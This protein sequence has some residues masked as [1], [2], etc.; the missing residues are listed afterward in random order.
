M[1]EADDVIAL[2]TE[3]NPDGSIEVKIV[4]RINTTHDNDGVLYKCRVSVAN[5]VDECKFVMN[6]TCKF[7]TCNNSCIFESHWNAE[8]ELQ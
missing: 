7:S 5:T 2:E 4:T 3:D 6:I 8:K 1:D